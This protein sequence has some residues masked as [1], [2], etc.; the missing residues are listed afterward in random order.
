[1]AM[2]FNKVVENVLWCLFITNLENG[3][4]GLNHVVFCNR[5]FIYLR[6][7]HWIRKV[8]FLQSVDGRKDKNPTR[9]TCS[10]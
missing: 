3:L 9:K 8:G 5:D 4:P 7:K 2:F 10:E 6:E 1:M